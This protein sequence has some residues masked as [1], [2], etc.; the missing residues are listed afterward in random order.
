MRFS[1]L[2]LLLFLSFVQVN[3]QYSSIN[4]SGKIL[5]KNTKSALEY[6]KVTLINESDSQFVAATYSDNKGLF[7]FS[8]IV[9]NTYIV[10]V[11]FDNYSN[12]SQQLFIG[13]SSDVLDLGK[14]E[15]E[16][17]AKQLRKIVV[18]SKAQTDTMQFDKKV[19]QVDDNISQSGGSILQI[20]QNLPSV[21]IVDGKLALRGNGNVVILIDG[22]QT[23]LTG[24]GSQKDLDNIP[25]SSVERIEIINNP[26]SKYDANGNAGIVNIILKKNIKYGLNGKFTLGTGLGA[27]WVRKANLPSVR[28]Q[29]QNTPKVNPS[30]SLNYRRK[31]VNLF[32]Q[33]DDLYTHT[34]N[35]NEFTSRFYDDGTA[36]EQQ[37]KRNRNTNFFTS[38]AGMDWN[39]SKNDALTFYVLYGN[40]KIIDRGDEAFFNSDKI[41]RIRM[42]QF[43]EDEF[44]TTAMG[45]ANY[46]HR[47]KELGHQINFNVNYTFHR[48]DEKYY[49]NNFVAN[50]TGNDSF[51]LL[52]DEKVTDF[53]VNYQKPYRYGKIESGIKYRHRIIN[54]N[55]DFKPGINSSIDSNA[56][57]WANYIEDIPALFGNWVFENKKFESEIG[58]RTEY[59]NLNYQV[60]P[61]HNTYKS[62]GYSYF[63]LF[64]NLKMVYKFNDKTKFNL[65]FNSRV[66][67]PNE[68]DIRIFPKYDDAEIIKVGNP[69]LKPQYTQSLDIGVSK[70]LS[71]NSNLFCS[72]YSKQI[73]GTI[74]RI[75]SIVPGQT[76][77]YA[78]FQNAGKSYQSGFELFFYNKFSKQYSINIS[79]NA[80]KNQ[81][82]AFSV[83]NK[84][85][86]ETVYTAETEK[87]VSG[88]VKINNNVQLSKRTSGQF[89]LNYYGPDI[90]PQGRINQRLSLD[91]GFKM[92][93]KNKKSEVYFNATDALNTMIVKKTYRGKGFNYS[94]TDYYETQ[95]FR[96]GYSYSF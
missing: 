35:K 1:I 95:V 91:F 82:N 62:N 32:F 59:V 4:L 77:I 29:Y 55:M 94:T 65:A 52:S 83:V 68:V 61:N 86:F 15:L 84:Y 81:I 13:S 89:T 46:T 85:P 54:T 93:L 87:I 31:K 80:F 21:S 10:E 88:N 51:K 11:T 90:I 57:G 38:K 45:N 7:K 79:V 44:K 63:K 60:N 14:L 75:S 36:I 73:N 78:V 19:I 20:M 18:A 25:A 67:R 76:L 74:T 33:F 56:G 3:A 30:L 69:A 49:F 28:P 53:S 72:F 64:P 22:Q 24:F 27:L 96:L 71:K 41:T 66:D 70:I 48:E 50:S 26:S 8:N 2:S 39:L 5:D 58:V 42:W 12:L 9:P 16:K 23:A 47:F 17:D 40:E 37:L 6:A 43:L 92:K 34:L